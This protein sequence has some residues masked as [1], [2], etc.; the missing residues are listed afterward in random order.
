MVAQEPSKRLL[1]IGLGDHEATAMQHLLLLG[2]LLLGRDLYASQAPGSTDL[3]RVPAATLAKPP[4]LEEGAS[5]LFWNPAAAPAEGS[6]SAGI[7]VIHTPDVL[8]LSGVIVGVS[9]AIWS[10]VNLGVVLGSM[11][12]RDLVRTISTP[13]SELGSIKVA[14]QVAGIVI[15][16]DVGWL[17][18]A[19]VARAHH[20][21]F[22]A[23]R[24]TGATVDIGFRFIPL[25][26]VT[27]AGATHFVPVDLNI[28]S[29]TDYFGGI[30]LL[31]TE[32]PLWGIRARLVMRY[33]SNHRSGFG[34][35][36]S[37]GTGL[38]L[39][40]EFAVDVHY[41]REERFG[42]VEW[43]PVMAVGLNMGRYSIAVAR[44]AGLN[45]VGATYRVGLE[46]VA[47]R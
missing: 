41:M 20:S 27:L 24:E 3:W 32:A 13:I 6:L 45:G 4:A 34:T 11:E 22:D 25:R 19:A 38:M 26:R 28:G 39:G 21:Q 42:Q 29:T 23:L 5:A 17:R 30:E 16:W 44:G 36:H 46:I 33:G 8:G 12:V 1:D 14:D 47:V 10:Q 37:M 35:D 15:G 9:T 31:L 7:Q 43:W 40:D 18:T 2:L